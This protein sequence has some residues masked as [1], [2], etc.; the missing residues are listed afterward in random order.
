MPNYVKTHPRIFLSVICPSGICDLYIDMVG[1]EA[2]YREVPDCH[3]IAGNPGEYI[4]QHF[5]PC[6]G[7]LSSMFCKFIHCITF[8]VPCV[9]NLSPAMGARNQVGMVVVPVRQPI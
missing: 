9:G 6:H 4:T 3:P 2:L 8:F 1:L 5:I 7:L